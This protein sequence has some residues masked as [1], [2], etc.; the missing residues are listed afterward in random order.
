[1]MKDLEKILVLNEKMS[2]IAEE[3][4]RGIYRS[5]NETVGK[6]LEREKSRLKRE[7]N[8]FVHDVF[9]K[10]YMRKSK[11]D[12]EMLRQEALDKVKNMRNIPKQIE[13]LTQVVEE[14]EEGVQFIAYNECFEDCCFTKFRIET[15]INMARGGASLT[16]IVKYVPGVEIGDVYVTVHDMLG[17]PMEITEEEKQQI[18]AFKEKLFSEEKITM[19]DIFNANVRLK[20]IPRYSSCELCW[21]WEDCEQQYNTMDA[22]KTF[23]QTHL[24]YPYYCGNIR[25]EHGYSFEDVVYK[26]MMKPEEFSIEGLEEYYGIQ[27]RNLLNRTKERILEAIERN[28]KAERR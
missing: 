4:V 23:S 26:L 5:I 8:N 22:A 7:K 28:R 24:E 20:G 9:D 25:Q 17:I 19:A 11:E 13:Y 14:I 2:N 3:K 1:M 21:E 6:K 27:E 15:C 16:Q 12:Y 18:D 10:K